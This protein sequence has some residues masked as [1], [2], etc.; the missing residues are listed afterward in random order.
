M[1]IIKYIYEEVLK[2]Y[3][4]QTTLAYILER[5]NENKERK[6]IFKNHKKI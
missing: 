6:T 5:K 4:I 1:P 3:L 2:E